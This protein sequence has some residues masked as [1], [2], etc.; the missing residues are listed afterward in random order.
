MD[1]HEVIWKPITCNAFQTSSH[2]HFSE[3]NLDPTCLSHAFFRSL[4]SWFF[5]AGETHPRLEDRRSAAVLGSTSDRSRCPDVTPTAQATTHGS[6][7]RTRRRPRELT[8][9][10]TVTKKP[11]PLTRIDSDGCRSAAFSGFQSSSPSRQ[12]KWIGIFVMGLPPGSVTFNS[13]L[14]IEEQYLLFVVLAVLT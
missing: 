9:S 8:S 2:H 12:P 3:Q 4:Q 11:T 1:D 5:F 14:K 13:A 7:Q 6:T 10:S